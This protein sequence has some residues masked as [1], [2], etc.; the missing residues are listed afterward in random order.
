MRCL[1]VVLCLAPLCGCA[2]G[3]AARFVDGGLFTQTSARERVVAQLGQ[4]YAD[5]AAAERLKAIAGRLVRANPV[6]PQRLRIELLGGSCLNAA[7]LPPNQVFISRGLYA[8]LSE[9]ACLAAVLAHELAHL[10]AGDHTKARAVSRAALGEREAAADAQATRYLRAAGYRP[11]AMRS[12][13]ERLLR[14]RTSEMLCERREQLVADE[15]PADNG[16]LAQR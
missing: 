6:L 9:E 8:A 11:C 7:S 13:I 16:V 1:S 10:A 12:V 2:T 4:P 15:R 3:T 14:Q 5:P